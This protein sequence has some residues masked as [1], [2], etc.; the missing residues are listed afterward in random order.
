[1]NDRR[2]YDQDCDCS[3]WSSNRTSALDYVLVYIDRVIRS[4]V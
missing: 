3:D 1:M 4:F 2:I